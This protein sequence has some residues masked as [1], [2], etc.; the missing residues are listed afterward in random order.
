MMARE[1][2]FERPGPQYE[3]LPSL[4][5]QAPKKKAFPLFDTVRQKRVGSRK[6]LPGLQDSL[7]LRTVLQ[8]QRLP[9]RLRD[10]L[11]TGSKGGFGQ[12]PAGAFT[13]K[14]D[15]KLPMK[16]HGGRDS[17]VG[18]SFTGEGKEAFKG[19]FDYRHKH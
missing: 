19:L 10:L 2:R 15:S 11:P 4:E 5:G 12:K 17:G 7:H 1:R 3:N 6:R 13:M 14:H 9:H 8:R 18:R 16:D